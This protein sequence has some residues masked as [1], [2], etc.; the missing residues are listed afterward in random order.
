MKLNEIKEILECEILTGED[1]LQGEI[2]YGCG[3]D[4]MSDVLAFSQEGSVLLTGLT[5]I[6]SVRTAYIAGCKAIVYV[7]GKK[8]DAET[9]KIAREKGMPLL[10]TNLRLYDA[11][12]KLYVKGLKNVL[13]S[14]KSVP[15]KE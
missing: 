1:T 2:S 13:E 8:P 5:N 15:V 7:R 10:A 11:C 9:I 12:G 14:A 4:L 3:C 6:Q